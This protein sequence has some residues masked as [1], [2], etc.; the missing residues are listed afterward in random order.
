MPL[1]TF[2]AY[3]VLKLHEFLAYDWSIFT[4]LNSLITRLKVL[5][6]D[7]TGVLFDIDFL[8]YSQLIMKH[9]IHFKVILGVLV[10]A[11][12]SATLD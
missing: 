5:C 2:T 7:M 4:C 11:Q 1:G 3:G 8:I 12:K 10:A 9:L 6:G